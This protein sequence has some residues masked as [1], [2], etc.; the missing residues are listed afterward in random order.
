M[1]NPSPVTQ[2]EEWLVAEDHQRASEACLDLLAENPADPDLL[3]LLALSEELAGQTEKAITRL[4][5]VTESHPEHVRSLF[6]LG[7]LFA[8]TKQS[9]AAREALS[10][11]IAL[12]PNHAPSRT[13]LA[14]LDYQ[15]GDAAPALEGLR[16]ALR[17]DPDYVPALCDLTILLV[18]RG[19]IEEAHSHASHAV[20]IAS[21]EGSAQLAM[22]LV[23]EAQG[24][25]GF[26]EQCLINATD[27][28]PS[29]LQGLMALS[30]VYQQ[31][32]EHDQALAVLDRLSDDGKSQPAA[33]YARAFSLMR[34]GQLAPARALYESLVAEKPDLKTALQL[35]DLYIQQND[36][37]ALVDLSQSID[38][39]VQSGQAAGQFVDARLAEF[40]GQLD[41]AIE[42][43]KSLDTSGRFEFQVRVHLLLARLYLK[44]GEPQAVLESLSTLAEHNTVH[45]RVRW[46]MAQLA[47][48][49]GDHAFALKMIDA[50]LRDATLET[51]VL[52]RTRTMRLHVLD[53]LERFDEAQAEI[54]DSSRE[55]GWLPPPMPLMATALPDLSHLMSPSPTP[56]VNPPA[57][58]WAPGWPWAGR[59]LI[60]AAL[61]QINGAKVLPMAEGATR[62]QHLGLYPGETPGVGLSPDQ[63][64]PMARRYLRAADNNAACLIEPFPCRAADLIRLWAVF[65]EAMA[66]RVTCQPNYLRL[67]WHLAGY[68]TVDAMLQAWLDE[69]KALDRVAQETSFKVVSV[70]LEDLLDPSTIESAIEALMKALSQPMSEKMSLHVRALAQRHGYRPATHWTHYF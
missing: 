20:K 10:A 15:G 59:E 41:E 60:L 1:S 18:E 19:S 2:I 42:H 69:Q 58:I 34:M 6:H 12:S 65:P 46:E 62:H 66:V 45:Y 33:R 26:A 17:A 52:G 8:Q 54:Q 51:E 27:Q 36:H 29:S 3:T 21:D 11:S 47:E 61:A 70:A 22:G 39:T 40:A 53:R 44:K 35:V 16:V 57:L 24:H 49:A 55:M 50:V 64:H 38:R 9:A 25:I 37:Q 32:G 13:M 23:F 7:R 30:R 28:D 56:G 63:A 5:S 48:Q 14:R 43:L 31:K 68:R 67:Q 4:Q